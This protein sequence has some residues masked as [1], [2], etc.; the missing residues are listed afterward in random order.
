MYGSDRKVV[1]PTTV[2]P[3]LQ[4][5]KKAPAYLTQELSLELIERVGYTEKL[6]PQ[7]QDREA[8]GL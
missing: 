7:P 8:F 5:M 1:S 3:R 2:P 6:S 4:Y